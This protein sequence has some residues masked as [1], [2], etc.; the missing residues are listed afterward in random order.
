MVDRERGHLSLIQFLLKTT[1]RGCLGR[2]VVIE[3][4]IGS[5]WGLLC[6]ER[7]LL[8]HSCVFYPEGPHRGR[9]FRKAMNR[10]A[11]PQQAQL[12]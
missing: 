8:I 7:R 11:F 2:E 1:K 9:G 10:K 6:R 3:S 12:I 4:A 5:P